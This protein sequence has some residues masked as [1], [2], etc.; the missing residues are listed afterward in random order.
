MSRPNVEP[1]GEEGVRGQIAAA[2]QG[3]RDA[4]L[5]AS[6]DAVLMSAEDAQALGLTEGDRVQVRS[7]VGE[8]VRRCR[9]V[10]IKPR[11][12]QV[13][14]PEANALM[15]RGACDPQCGIPDYHTLVELLPLGTERPAGEGIRP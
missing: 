4:L 14:W 1:G 15:R 5:G 7:D 10:P 3:S 12:V 13:Y 2:R 8:L 9:I 6:R 11:N